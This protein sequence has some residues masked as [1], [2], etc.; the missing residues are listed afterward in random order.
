M[1]VQNNAEEAAVNGTFGAAA[2]A[3]AV[4]VSSLHLYAPVC[5]CMQLYALNTPGFH[6]I[7]AL[8]ALREPVLSRKCSSSSS[9]VTSREAGL[10]IYVF[11]S[12]FL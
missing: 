12:S 4:Q 7:T 8:E 1:R 9:R 10:V 3:E 5:M 6:V 2:A 11:T